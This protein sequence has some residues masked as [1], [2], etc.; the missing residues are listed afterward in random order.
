MHGLMTALARRHDLTAL[1]LVDAEYDLEECRRAMGEYCRQVVLVP[2]PR[3]APGL[4]KRTLQLR[5]LFSRHSFEHHCFAV[6]ALQE[7]LD[8]VQRQTPFDVVNLGFPYLAH[9]RLSQAPAGAP[10]PPLV[11]DSHEIAHDMVR[12]FTASA[13]S[14]GRKL[15]GALDWRKLRQ[16]ELSAFRKADGVSL[17]SL[18]DQQ[19]LLAEVPEARTAVVP[20]AADVE[21]YQ[22]RPS[23]P[24]ADG[25]TVLFF[26]LLSTLP[27]LDGIRWFVREIWPRVLRA[28]GDARLKIMGKSAP[29]AVR[30]LAGPDVEVAGFADDL[31]PHLAAAAVVVVPLRLGGGTRLKIIEGMAMGKGIV[32]T[33]LGAEG[34]EATPE[35]D[36]L[37]AD[38]PEDFARDVLRLLEEPG[39]AAR[40]GA[41]G[42][43]LAVD[44]Y[45]WTS[46]AARLESFYREI[47]LARGGQGREERREVTA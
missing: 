44:R 14:L 42:R 3:G 36:L 46:A 19:R 15:Y 5:S 34:I 16:E 40:L 29:P 25:R 17:C 28:R 21:F 35:R 4:A 12:Q 39:L 26:G 33:T 13:G 22:P 27:N 1:S 41:A 11:V 43:R 10:P 31:R 20:N 38:R 7:A 18:A 23:D 6:P 2:N 45:A 30:A 37:I 32:S 8:R 9:F 47:F 24:P